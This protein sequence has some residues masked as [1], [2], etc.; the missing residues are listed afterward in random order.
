MEECFLKI[1]QSWKHS[2]GGY[3]GNGRRVHDYPNLL[4]YKSRRPSNM[5]YEEPEYLWGSLY[6]DTNFV[7]NP[8][9]K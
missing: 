7:E 2:G 1:S 9:L 5:P 8:V 6:L 3:L 4:C